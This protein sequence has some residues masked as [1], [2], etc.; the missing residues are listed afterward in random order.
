[1]KLTDIINSIKTGLSSGLSSLKF[2]TI[3]EESLRSQIE[4][5]R[6]SLLTVEKAVNSFN[7]KQFSNL[8][9]LVHN[10]L[11]FSPEIVKAVGKPAT[12]FI[13]GIDKELKGHARSQGFFKSM[14]VT[15]KQMLKLLDSL[16]ENIPMI[17]QAKDGVVVT[18]MMVSHTMFIGALESVKLFSNF[19]SYMLVV[20]SHIISISKLT[21]DT[22]MPKYMVDYLVTNGMTCITLLNQ[23]TN[24]SSGSPIINTIMNMRKQGIDTRLDS[25]SLISY[26]FSD[27][28]LI[29]PSLFRILISPIT[30][31]G[32]LYIE[33]RHTY[34][35]RLKDQ[36]KWLECHTANIKLILNETS[37]NDIEYVKN[38]K[39]IL[40]YDDKIAAIDKKIQKYYS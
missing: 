10:R 19:C 37:E 14:V 24:S 30:I 23:F 26:N 15:I 22:A 28:T 20:F 9:G 5:T 39:I 34:Y 29:F 21:G 32:E 6:W 31:M 35:E 36:K 2:K 3:S 16:E 13:L 18:D 12:D 38:K 33:A 40:F 8:L 4:D 25:K 11:K 1:V 27:D 7:D 17:L